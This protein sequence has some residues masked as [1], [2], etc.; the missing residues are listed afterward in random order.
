L[1]PLAVVAKSVSTRRFSATGVTRLWR[2]KPRVTAVDD[3]SPPNIP[4]MP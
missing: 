4:A 1:Q 3:T 2:E